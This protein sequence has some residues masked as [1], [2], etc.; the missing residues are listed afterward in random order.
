MYEGLTQYLGY[1]LAVCWLWTEPLPGAPGGKS[2][3]TDTLPGREWRPLVDTT[4]AAQLPHAARRT[5]GR[6]FGSTDF[7]DEGWLIWLDADTMIRQLSAGKMSLDDFCRKFHGVRRIAGGA[8]VHARRCRGGAERGRADD[9]K[10]FLTARVTRVG[11]HA[12]LDGL[13][14]GGW[15]LTYTDATTIAPARVR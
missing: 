10:T 15:Q 14:R 9:W 1:V 4:I 5:T 8:A 3:R 12:P 2:R 6:P 11:G 13:A 7:Y